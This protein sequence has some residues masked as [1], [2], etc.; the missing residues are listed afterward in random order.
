MSPYSLLQKI[1][2]YNIPGLCY[3]PSLPRLTSHTL[4]VEQLI[5]FSKEWSFR[6]KLKVEYRQ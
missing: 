6:I 1:K 2:E 4:T 5:K 3:Y